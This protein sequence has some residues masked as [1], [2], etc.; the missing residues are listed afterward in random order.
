MLWSTCRGSHPQRI[1][2]KHMMTRPQSPS[3]GPATLRMRY[4]RRKNGRKK[5]AGQCC[6]YIRV[7]GN[8]YYM[9][10]LHGKPADMDL[11]GGL[12]SKT[13]NTKTYNYCYHQR[14]NLPSEPDVQHRQRTHVRCAVTI[15]RYASVKMP[16]SNSVTYQ[17]HR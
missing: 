6:W 13:V 14:I 7:R 8:W 17:W 3:G 5:V 12:D 2:E 10:L 9:Y 1:I 15:Q 16:T 4:D 11:S